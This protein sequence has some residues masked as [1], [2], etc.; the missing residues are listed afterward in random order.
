LFLFF[1]I[2][3]IFAKSYYQILFITSCFS[4]LIKLN[5]IQ[6]VLQSKFIFCIFNMTSCITILLCAYLTLSAWELIVGVSPQ[7]VHSGASKPALKDGGLPDMTWC[8]Q[9]ESQLPPGESVANNVDRSSF[10]AK[11]QHCT[12]LWIQ[13]G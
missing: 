7:K 8:K 1:Y 9:L 11:V 13:S 10:D 4:Y 12:K 6:F 3:A 5:A 2:L